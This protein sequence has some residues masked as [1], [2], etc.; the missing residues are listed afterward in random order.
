VTCVRDDIA[1]FLIDQQASSVLAL[2]IFLSTRSK[3]I[4]SPISNQ[5]KLF[6]IQFPIGFQLDSIFQLDSNG[7][8]ISNRIPTD[9]QFPIGIRLISRREMYQ[10]LQ[11]G[12]LKLESAW[13]PLS[14]WIPMDFQLE[15]GFQLESIW[16]LES[17]WILIGKYT[18]RQ[19]PSTISV[20][21]NIRHTVSK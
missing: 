8:P 7:C 10:L 11:R 16:Q 9:F 4:S 13:F 1:D 19:K 2:F 3:C 21:S 15:I 14:N 20:Y 5:K 18:A 6:P 17:N 12:E